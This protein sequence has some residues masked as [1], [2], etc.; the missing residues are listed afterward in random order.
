MSEEKLVRRIPRTLPLLFSYKVT[1]IRE[2]HDVTTMKLDELIGSVTSFEMSLDGEEGD[3][4]KSLALRYKICDGEESKDSL[5][6]TKY[7]LL[8]TLIRV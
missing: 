7:C 3:R 4:K 8:R 6:E 1:T 2:A 5:G